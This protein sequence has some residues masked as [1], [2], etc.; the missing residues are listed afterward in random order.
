VVE[1]LPI[2]IA[3]LALIAAA[4]ALA[5]RF[6]LPLPVVLALAGILLAFVPGL[7]RARL[8]PELVLVLFLPPLLYADAFDTSWVDFRRWLRPI[9][10]LAVGLVAWTIL[11]V[12]LVAR[13]MLPELPWPACFILGAIVSPTDTVAVQSVLERLRLPRRVT[14]ILGGESLVNDATGL[15][16]VQLG[17]AVVL[18]GAFEAGEIALRFAWVAGGAVAIGVLCGGVFAVLNRAF[19]STEALFALSLLAPYGAFEAAHALETSGVLAVVVTGFV[20]AW[21]VHTIPPEARVDLF[22]TWTLLVSVLNSVCFVFVGLETPRLWRDTA[23]I[24]RE[25]LLAAGLVVSAAVVALRLLW[26]FHASYLPLLLSPRL[27][28]R[29]GGYPPWRAVVLTGWC[30]VRGAVSLAAALALPAELPDGRPFP[31]RSAILACTICVIL[32]TLF[33][34]AP[35]LQPLVRLLRI[36]EDGAGEEEE[37]HARTVMVQAGIQRLDRFCSERECP[38]SVHRWRELMS[39]ELAAMHA[40]DEEERRRALGQLE[41]SREVRRAVF[42]AKSQ[43]LLRLRDGGRINDRTFLGLQLELDREARATAGGR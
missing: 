27:R 5:S 17:V 10:M 39:D 6:R 25:R 22:T 42:E 28:E 23:L 11:V 33:L 13:A 7:P 16:G 18:T 30:G 21:R 24:D 29:E 40:E 32:V 34:Q 38:L 3:L 36:R 20:V 9:A 15:V 37:R 35:T 2:L 8:D 4:G 43:E 12:G 19:R 31:G 14:A 26:V 1:H 41:V